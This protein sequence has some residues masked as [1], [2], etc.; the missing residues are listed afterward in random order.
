MALWAFRCYLDANGVD[1]IRAAHAEKMRQAR[2]KFLSRLSALATLPF[3]E[4]F[5][6]YYKELHGVAAGVGEIRFKADG[7]QQRVLGYRSGEREF[8]LLLWATE[9]SGRFVPLAAPATA[10]SRKAETEQSKDRSH[11]LWLALE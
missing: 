9:K 1:Q 4:W 2:N 10:L 3:E 11:A 7:V 8:T 5:G 6:A